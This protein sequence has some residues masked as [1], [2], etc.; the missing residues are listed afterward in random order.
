[1]G[2]LAEPCV[3]KSGSVAH[4]DKNVGT[5]IVHFYD[6]QRRE[7]CNKS[8]LIIS[9]L[10]PEQENIRYCVNYEKGTGGKLT[11]VHKF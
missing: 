9:R 11:V 1:M 7:I 8:S 5:Y 2:Q 3:E 10:S 6:A 4:D